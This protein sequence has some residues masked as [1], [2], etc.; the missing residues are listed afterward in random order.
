MNTQ[1]A[2]SHFHPAIQSWVNELAQDRDENFSR[3]IISCIERTTI[4]LRQF[5][6]NTLRDGNDYLIINTHGSYLI[7]AQELPLNQELE[8]LRI[9][10][11]RLSKDEMKQVSWSTIQTLLVGLMPYLT[12]GGKATVEWYQ[13][14]LQLWRDDPPQGET[15]LKS[16][17]E[18]AQVD[19]H[20]N[21]ATLAMGV[22]DYVYHKHKP[23]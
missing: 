15:I 22:I 18:R 12:Y 10:L 16:I 6:Q 8:W 1:N 9:C 3:S 5:I 21:L 2:T 13:L 20:E 11:S 4:R 23:K 19:P 17:Y 7:P 14:I